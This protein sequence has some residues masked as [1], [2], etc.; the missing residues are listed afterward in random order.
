MNETY[1]KFMQRLT[2]QMERTDYIIRLGTRYSGEKDYTYSN[3]VLVY[4]GDDTFQWLN[5]W[6]EG[7]DDVI[8]VGYIPVAEISELYIC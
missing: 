2:S 7:Q 5:D 4:D 1:E 3:E 6:D 8:V